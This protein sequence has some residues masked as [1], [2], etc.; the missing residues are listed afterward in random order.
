MLS[1]SELESLR[2]QI[3]EA[4]RIAEQVLNKGKNKAAAWV[5]RTSHD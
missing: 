5:T 4:E 1:K 2:R 3:D